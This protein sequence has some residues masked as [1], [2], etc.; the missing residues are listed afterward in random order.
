MPDPPSGFDSVHVRKSN[1]QQN[2]VWLQFFRLLDSFQSIGDFA[3]DLQVRP[4]L[5][6]CGKELPKGFEILYD[7]NTDWSR[8]QR[9]SL[10]GL[11][12]KLIVGVALP[13]LRGSEL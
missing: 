12:I 1:V 8:S 11:N 2:Q 4:L 10:S 9:D 6:R 5:Q 7:K 13:E 3:N